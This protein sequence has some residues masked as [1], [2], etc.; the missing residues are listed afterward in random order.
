MS[1]NI[2]KTR[3]RG[4]NLLN[5]QMIESQLKK[6]KEGVSWPK[7]G[8]KKLSDGGNLYLFIKRGGYAYWHFNFVWGGKSQTIS[9]GVYPDVSL[10]DARDKAI[11]TR[12]NLKNGIR[13][14]G[15]Y[16]IKSAPP[17]PSQKTFEVVCE[18]WFEGWKKNQSPTTI[19]RKLNIIK[20]Y[21][22]PV[23]G[24]TAFNLVD[25]D[26][27]APIAL[28][29]TN[30]RKNKTSGTL[31]KLFDILTQV[32]D[33]AK[34]NRRK[35]EGW[36][37]LSEIVDDLK[38][39]YP[40]LESAKHFPRVKTVPELREVLQK[41]KCYINKCPTQNIIFIRILSMIFCRPG[42][43]ITAKWDDIKH[44]MWFQ[45]EP[46]IVNTKGRVIIPLPTQVLEH[47]DTL[48]RA[49]EYGPDPENVYLFPS[50]QKPGSHLN[51]ETIDRLLRKN[52]GLKGIQCLHGF[53]GTATT[54]LSNKRW[55]LEL[56]NK[57]LAHS[58][59]KVQ[60]AYD[61]SDKLPERAKMLQFWADFLDGLWNEV[62]DDKLPNPK[63]EKY[64]I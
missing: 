54:I 10:T 8:I 45:P 62:D 5:T 46:D 28:K 43:L 29:L 50:P 42:E 1:E 34:H 7:S 44:G 11:L 59:G 40:R 22:Y 20:R 48:K 31:D 23:I 41:I 53:R 33:Y 30:E 51:L 19:R 63:N 9:Y 26:Q 52:M 36:T 56:I 21:L 37:N 49:R 24:D 4:L 15:T 2:K 27:I 18:E 55:S 61:D 16:G 17:D 14:L 25:Y 58:F 57:E 39:N 6:A 60:K 3:R 47:L 35:V 12:Q 13:P 64:Q 38:A 32:T